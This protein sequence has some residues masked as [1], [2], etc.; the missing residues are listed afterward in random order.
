MKTSAIGWLLS[1]LAAL[2]VGVLLGE[3]FDIGMDPNFRRDGPGKS[4]MGMDLVPVY[5]SADTEADDDSSIRISPAVE[6]NLGVRTGEVSV[7]PLW[8]RVNATGYIGFDENLLSRIH[9]RTEGWV[10]RVEVSAVG[11]RVRKGQ[12]LFEFYSPQLV[13]AQKEYLQASRRNERSIARA[14]RE[15]LLALGMV[16]DEIDA[17]AARGEASQTIRVLAPMNGVVTA[18]MAREGMY[19]KPETEVISLADLSSV[20]MLAE[21]FEAQA[22]WVAQ[23]QAAEARLDYMPGEV[24]SGQVDYVYPVLDPGTR[25]LRVRLHFDNPD[26]RLKPNMYAEVTIF[27]K[28]H[29][30]ALTIPREALIRAEDSDRVIL[31]LGDGR[32]RAQQVMTGIESGNWIQIIAGLEA[33]QQVVTSAQFLIDS[34]ASL[35]GSFQRLEEASPDQRLKEARTVFGSGKVEQVN[36]QQRWLTIRHGPIDALGWP[37]MTMRFEVTGAVDLQ[38]IRAGQ[39]VHFSI[40]PDEQGVYLVDMVHLVDA[41]S[42]KVGPAEVEEHD[43]D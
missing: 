19:L 41:P 3:R 6:Q 22:D 39:N 29:T 1:V 40:R 2:A 17:L 5:A 9:M 33:G 34:E 42:E 18:L 11:E 31:A 32:Y 43:H 12:L 23:G 35:A 24:F 8:R 15:K 26:E 4:P 25:T 14:A 20:W 28:A 16:A 7:R 10:E 37:S 13:N 30:D 38:R 36:R 21:V 27:G